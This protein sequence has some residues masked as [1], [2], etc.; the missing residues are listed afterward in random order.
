MNRTFEELGTR[1]GDTS[2][3]PAAVVTIAHASVFDRARELRALPI[4]RVILNNVLR[5]LR[6]GYRVYTFEVLS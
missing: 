2:N 1:F 3:N 5:G 4:P 6:D